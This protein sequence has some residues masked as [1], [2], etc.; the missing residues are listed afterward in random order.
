MFDLTGGFPTPGLWVHQPTVHDFIEM[1]IKQYVEVF[2]NRGT[3]KWMVYEGQ[4]Y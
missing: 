2:Q 4:S 1:E 3:Q